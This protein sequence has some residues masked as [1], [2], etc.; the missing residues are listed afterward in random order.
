MAR[1][2]LLQLKSYLS[3]SD[4]LAVGYVRNSKQVGGNLYLHM[5]CRVYPETG[6]TEVYYSIYMFRKQDLDYYEKSF[7][8]YQE[9]TEQYNKLIIQ[10]NGY[11]EKPAV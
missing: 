3:A 6:A 10:F 7:D 5:T 1:N 8:S 2:E 4:I 11:K 9:A